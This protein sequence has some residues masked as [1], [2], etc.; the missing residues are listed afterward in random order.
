MLDN[1]VNNTDQP[2]DGY[3]VVARPV[4]FYEL[5]N[6]R[7]D[8]GRQVTELKPS[9]GGKPTFMGSINVRVTNPQGQQGHIAT[10][11]AIVADNTEEA[12]FVFDTEATCAAKRVIEKA[13]EEMR[14]PQIVVPELRQ[15]RPR[16]EG[17]KPRNRF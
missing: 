11:F 9:D 8:A 4:K 15:Q 17:Y 10:S 16:F 2:K 5:H 14:K 13:Q 6:Y 12:F 1:A 7:D 3:E